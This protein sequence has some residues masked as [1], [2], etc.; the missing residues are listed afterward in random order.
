MIPNAHYSNVETEEAFADRFPLPYSY[1]KNY[2]GLLRAR[3]SYRR[4]QSHLPFYVIY[5]V[6]DYTFSPHKVVWMEQ[7]DPASFRAVVVSSL[8]TAEAQQ[9]LVVPDHKL[10]FAALGSADEAHY[11]CGF[12]NSAPVRAWLGGFLHGKQIAT[13]IFEYMNVPAYDPMN[14]RC[15]AIADILNE[16]HST[17]ANMREPGLLDDNTERLLARHVK[18]VCTP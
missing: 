6:G 18:A 10:Y 16:A 17:R 3:A 12:L 13:T 4:Y 8:D 14:A 15:I 9:K 7:Q 5:C 11:L 1:L 2:E